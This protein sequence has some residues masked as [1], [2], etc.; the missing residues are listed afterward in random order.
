MQLH[1]FER[2]D[3]GSV[4][5]AAVDPSFRGPRLRPG[6]FGNFLE[7]LTGSTVGGIEAGVC[8]NPTLVSSVNLTAKQQEEFLANGRQLEAHA[9]EGRSIDRTWH[10]FPLATG[11]GVAVLDEPQSG[12]VSYAE[13]AMPF[14]WIGEGGACSDMARLGTGVRLPGDAAMHQGVFLPARGPVALLVTVTAQAVGGG[15]AELEVSL[16]RRIGPEAGAV[17]ARANGALTGSG[18][19]EI[20]LRLDAVTTAPG[21]P[22]DLWVRRV[23]DGPGSVVIDR[24]WALPSDHV[25]G[26]DPD[27]LDAARDLGVPWLRWP[28]GNFANDYHWRDGVGPIAHRPT[29]PNVTWGGV[30]TNTFGTHEYLRLCELIGAEPHITVNSGTGSPEEAA[31][32]V[33]Y[34]NG[35]EDTPMGALRAANGHPAPFGVT[36]W[37]IGNE[38]YGAWQAGCT[39]SDENARRFAAFAPAMRAAS[40]IPLTLLGCGNWFDLAP[41]G[42]DLQ[43]VSAD[44]AWHAE[45]LAAGAPDLDSISLHALPSNDLLLED[46]SEAEAHES[47]LAHVVTAERHQLPAL[48]ELA[49][50]ATGSRR[51]PATIS[52]TEWGP[53]GSR[54]D[55][56]M[57]EWLGGALYASTFLA[58]MARLGDHVLMTSPNGL[59]HGGG[60]KRAGGHVYTT[61]MADVLARWSTLAGS[62]PLGCR[63]TGAAFDVKH[64]TDLGDAETDVPRVDVFA[65]ARP[66]GDVAVVLTS[67]CWDEA[68]PVELRGLGSEA[69]IAELFDCT[70]LGATP[71]PS[72]RQVATW[73]P[74][75]VSAADDVLQVSVPA[76]SI[77]WLEL[78]APS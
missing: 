21:E 51:A 53:L 72:Q 12:P 75:E 49:R 57:V 26:L 55:R 69:R 77:V 18:W 25:D 66:T 71:T 68:R 1:T 61:P 47:I 19:Q 22:V 16:R 3:S 70:D 60:L 32:W 31:A 35:A 14:G 48:L 76:R 40:P 58:A 28:G 17:L 50:E 5:R 2:D 59:L 13:L 74:H 7:H 63:V 64:P 56:A 8:A 67:R 38:N 41:D 30:E 15:S 6:L 44:G 37:E 11:F 39:G 65:A 34:C 24:V 10:P 4:D 62:E 33:E 52:V 20:E 27:L 46:A 23:A 45:L 43:H 73:R 78:A 42:R 9:R 36:V 29:R 54:T